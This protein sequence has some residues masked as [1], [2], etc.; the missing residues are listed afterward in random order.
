MGKTASVPVGFFRRLWVKLFG[1][2]SQRELTANELNQVMRRVRAECIRGAFG[3]VCGFVSDNEL[4]I[5]GEQRYED[6][7][8]EDQAKIDS[9]AEVLA[10]GKGEHVPFNE[11]KFEGEAD[12]GQGAVTS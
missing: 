5:G 1:L 9:I 4:S 11:M 12:S 7:S 8:P 3:S 6:L 10:S 2:P